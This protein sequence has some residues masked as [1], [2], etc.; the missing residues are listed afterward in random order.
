MTNKTA[1]QQGFLWH[2]LPGLNS[3]LHDLSH[4]ELTTAFRFLIWNMEIIKQIICVPV[5]KSSII[6]YHGQKVMNDEWINTI[7]SRQH[8]AFNRKSWCVPQPD[9]PWKEGFWCKR[10]TRARFSLEQAIPREKSVVTAVP[11][12]GVW[13]VISDDKGLRAGWW[14]GYGNGGVVT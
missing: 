11:E 1:P 13:G 2:L 9:G 12:R 6:I 10:I 4:Y 3:A 8:S 7:W 14:E 5:L